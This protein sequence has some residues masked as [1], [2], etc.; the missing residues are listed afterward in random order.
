MAG[1]WAGE[2]DTLDLSPPPHTRKGQYWGESQTLLKFRDAQLP[3]GQRGAEVGACLLPS[4]LE[5][6]I[7]TVSTSV[8][9]QPWISQVRNTE[10]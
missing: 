2:D 10:L 8:G 1:E 7:S 3:H 9:H 6:Y 5:P 4:V